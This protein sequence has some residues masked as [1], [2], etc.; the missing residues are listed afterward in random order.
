MKARRRRLGRGRKRKAKRKKKNK[1]KLCTN[2]MK[3]MKFMLARASSKKCLNR[4][5]QKAAN[6]T[7][8]Y[9]AAQL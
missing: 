2:R 8:M 1:K 3:K 9:R 5:N 4:I 6:P 7:K